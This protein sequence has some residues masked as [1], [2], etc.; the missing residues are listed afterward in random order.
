MSESLK[1]C[2]IYG[3]VRSARVGIRAA[4]FMQAQAEARGHDVSFVDPM[5]EGIPLLDR[6]LVDFADG[7][8][9]ENLTR[10]SSL[11]ASV[12]G[13][14][15]VSGEYNHVTPPALTNLLD[16]FRSEYFYRPSGIVSYS[17]GSFGGVRATE[18]LRSL[19]GALGMPSI[20]SSMPIPRV[21]DAFDDEGRATDD[22]WSGRAERFFSELE[23]YARTLR[24]GRTKYGTP[25]M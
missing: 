10:L 11:F 16:H 19:L 5:A 15:I 13:Y 9:P 23:W 21:Q 25:S 12:D 1:L 2:V 22:A 14:V 20:P 24:D 17:G 8:A 7:E 18:H 3:S 4:K 6:R